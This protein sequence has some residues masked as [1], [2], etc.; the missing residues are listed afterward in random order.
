MSN[1]HLILRCENH[2]EGI[3]TAIYDAFEY[4]NQ[5]EKYEDNIAIEIG[6]EGNLSLFAR[7]EVVITNSDKARKTVY[8]IQKKLGYSVYDT[9]FYALCHFAPDRAS[10]VLGYLVRAFATGSCIREY[11]ADRYV[12]RVLEL[13]RK[14]AN[15]QQRFFGFLRFRD[16]GDFLFSELEPKCDML[17]VLVEHFSDR[18]PNEN[19]M[20]Y[21]RTRQYALVHPAFG[22][23]FFVSGQELDK[24]ATLTQRTM[25]L[26]EFELLWKQYFYC[27]A[28]EE[29]KNERCQNN[30]I[31]KWYRSTMIEHIK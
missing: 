26:D 9:V 5:M 10:V 6:N 22:R 12:M 15:E 29:R 3:L 16:M 24:I 27:M 31:P 25:D 8:A 23:S 20:I 11:M 4:K 1:Y 7:E 28:I 14:V 18:Y 17:P 13:S 21:D 2:I 19:F 30:A